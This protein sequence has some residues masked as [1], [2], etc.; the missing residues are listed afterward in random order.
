LDQA[1][2]HSRAKANTGRMEPGSEKVD[3]APG[4]QPIGRRGVGSQTLWPIGGPE[5]DL[6]RGGFAVDPDLGKCPIP[7]CNPPKELILMI[8]PK[9]NT[10]ENK[11]FKLRICSV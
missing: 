1:K 8:C 2:T 4:N 7:E 5:T 9:E 11:I 10:Y 6:G 3:S